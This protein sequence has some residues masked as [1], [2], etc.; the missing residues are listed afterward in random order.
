MEIIV[1]D[2]S[3]I[4]D[5]AK[6]GL[7]E[8]MGALPY[9]FTIPDVLFEDELI[10]LGDYHRNDLLRAGFKIGELSGAEVETAFSYPARYPALTV[11]DCFAL[12]LSTTT[13]SILLTG[14]KTLR[15]AAKEQGVEV[16]GQLWV[17]DQINEHETAEAST[18]YEALRQWSEDPLVWVPGKPLHQRMERLRKL[19][20]R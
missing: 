15:V 7:I 19:M 2:S 9:L 10:N 18:L 8:N 3:V 4:I 12:A 20:D 13:A 1:S 17:C 11:N 14:D 6:V 5:L 16:H